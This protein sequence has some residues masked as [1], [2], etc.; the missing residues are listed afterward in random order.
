MSSTN[1]AL[2]VIDVINSC[3]DE[4]YE[5]PK[6]D[7]G[8]SRIREVVPKLEKFLKQYRKVV[9]GMVIFVKTTPWRKEFLTANI[10]EL[11]TDPKAAYYSEDTSGF[12][13]EF[14]KVTPQKGDT[15]FT[16]NHYDAFVNPKLD[17]TLKG[18]GIKYLVVAGIFGDGCV[19]ATV[20][21]G[22]SKGYNFV[23]LKDLIE[24]TDSKTRQELQKYLKEFT[25][26]IMYGRTL[27]S[28]EFLKAWKKF[29]P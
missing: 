20:C 2:L 16:K 21:G 3:A 7:I 23:I 28:S 25:W 26:P 15:I 14:Y 5:I 24:T 27:T 12:A 19:L 17:K 9:N 18:R 4:R 22:F 1:T 10:N 8:F 13:E 29:N 6:V 11:Y